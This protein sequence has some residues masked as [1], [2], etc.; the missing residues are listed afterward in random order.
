MSLEA[1]REQRILCHQ[2]FSKNT[3]RP[4]GLQNPGPVFA[5]STTLDAASAGVAI[6]A[7]AVVEMKMAE[8]T[9]MT[10]LCLRMACPPFSMQQ[11]LA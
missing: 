5:I 3:R 2:Q 8:R 6:R 7:C 9:A 10:M 11:A 4:I 1:L